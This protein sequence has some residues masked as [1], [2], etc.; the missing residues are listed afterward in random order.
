MTLYRLL[1]N[2]PFETKEKDGE[3]KAITCDS[4]QVE[5]GSVF[6]CIKGVKM[7]GHDHALSALESGAAAVV[8][9]RDLGIDKQV[10]VT[11]TRFAWGI[12]CAN[13]FGNPSKKLKLL[14]V[15]GT[16]GKTSITYIMKHILEQ[17]GKKV[18]LIGTIQ[19]EIGDMVVP[20]KHTTP[21][22]YQL[23]AMFERMHGAGCEYVVMEVSSHALEQQR[24]AGCH[25]AAAAFTNLTQDHLDY[26]GD[27]E[28]YYAAKKKL[29]SMCDVAVVNYDDTYGQRLL[30]ELDC[31][32]LT[33]SCQHDEA[34][35]TAKNIKFTAQQSSFVLL[36]GSDLT[37]VQ[38][39]MP[40]LFSVSNALAAAVACIAA[41]L[42]Y[43]DVIEGLLNCRG[44]P[45]RM[46]IL[47]TGTPYTVIR[48]YA[49]SPDG[50]EK[51]LTAVRAFAPARVVVL[52]GCAGNRDRTKRPKMAEA[53]ARLA[54]FCILTS[55]NPRDE[56]PMRIIEDAMPGLKKH[57]VAH[58][59]I[60]DRYAAIKWA[61]E[62]SRDDDVLVLAGK[63][64]ED[65][66]VLDYGTIFFDEKVIVSELLDKS[67]K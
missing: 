14:G 34:D 12:A 16:N 52:F 39:A 57:K 47:E 65:Y 5:R 23:H 61:L 49:H 55:D 18:G 2:V 43:D 44:V 51:M 27:M 7:D 8:V 60:A 3:I 37:R 9:Q 59:V 17:A 35:Y 11:D 32:K 6:F 46:E 40:G 10:I 63:G 45:G 54:D 28:H 66:Q 50:L 21:D 64:H 4:R 41:G 15:T 62:N 29:F 1:D 24:V 56:D 25:F 42:D 19:N 53:A 22:P 48:D 58:K 20:A 31:P 33:F 67:K 26:H 30:E 38:F 13:Y 36:H